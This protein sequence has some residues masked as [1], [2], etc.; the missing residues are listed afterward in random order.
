MLQLTTRT[1][2]ILLLTICLNQIA[3]A[4]DEGVNWPGFRGPNASGVAEKFATPTNWNGEENKNIKWKTAIPGLGHSS[5]IV[6]GNRI[7]ITTAISSKEDP[8]LRVGLYGDGTPVDDETVH[9]WK[10]FCLDKNT[11]R[12]LWEQ[13]AQEGVP[14]IKRHPKATHANCTMA[15]DGKYVVAFFGSEGLYCYDMNGKLIW[16]KDLGVLE[17]GPYDA[18]SLRWGFASSPVIYENMVMVQCDVLKN[19]FLAA[20]NIE[21]GKEIWRTT[22]ADVAAWSTPAVH[23]DGARTQLIVN[24]YKHIGSYDVQTGKELWRLAGGGDVPVP[25]PIVGHGLVFI[26]NAHGGRAPIYAIRLDA[27]G[28]ITL[29]DGAAANDYIV[30]SDGHNGNYMQTP[31]LYG[32]YL[33]TCKDGGVMTCYDAKTG[34]RFYRQRLGT[35]KS[36]FTASPVA[37]DGKIY[38]SSED[39]EI[40]VVQIGPEFKLLAV[41]PMGEICMATPAI[42]E[43]VLFFR[44]QNHLVAVK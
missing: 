44:T 3:L 8:Q 32:D 34:K 21:D 43:G 28:D 17:S 36:G 26:T 18:P 42:S 23:Q 22:R 16:K 25:T 9:H 33:F 7:F 13:T 40:Y 27:S 24:G 30:W 14:K 6:W 38:F 15:T 11:G 41:N 35:G 5:P 19:G 10:V 37:A 12:V 31:L 39:G 29:E 4:G 2:V 20:F 1:W